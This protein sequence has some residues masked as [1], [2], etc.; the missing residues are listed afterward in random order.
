MGRKILKLDM[1][2][3]GKYTLLNLLTYCQYVL[4]ILYCEEPHTVR[5][6]YLK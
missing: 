6:T 2:S 5:P 1:K 3:Y 4:F